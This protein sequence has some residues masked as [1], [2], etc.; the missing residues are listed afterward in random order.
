MNRAVADYVPAMAATPGAHVSG[1]VH[2]PLI[3]RVAAGR[4]TL[5]DQLFEDFFVLPRR[6]IGEGTLFLLEVSGDSMIES[7]IT[8]GDL[9][10]I[11]E[12]PTAENGET[13]AAMIDDEATIKTYK[14]VG[15]SIWLMPQN[16]NYQP[17]P[18]EKAIILGK[19]VAVIRRL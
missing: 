19:V 15:N 6:L 10:V 14:K 11:R 18:G 3:G 7:A 17:I 2:V 4:L 12:Q 8:N 13:V 16:P 5:A 9:V 1:Q